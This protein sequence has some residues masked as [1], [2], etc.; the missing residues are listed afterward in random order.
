MA[1]QLVYT[2]AAKLL[3]AGRSG[4]GT[5]ARSKAISPLVVSAI[6]R[7]SQFANLRGTDRSRMIFVHRRI[8]AGN[9]RCHVLSR[10][11]DAGADYTGRTNH[12]AHHLILSPDEVSHAAAAGVTPADILRQFAWRDR[13]DE[14]ARYFS[15]DEDVPME[16]FSPLGCQSARAEWTR[17]TGQPAHARLLAW[18]GAPRSGVLLVPR[19]TEPLALLA[20]ALCE[21]GSQAWCR[22][23]TTALESTDEMSDLDWIIS[24]PETFSEIQGRCGARTI[25]DLSQPDSLPVP[26]EPA[27]LPEETQPL[28]SPPAP[29]FPAVETADPGVVQVPVVKL[30]TSPSGPTTRRPVTIPA[31]PAVKQLGAWVVA[32][33]ATVVILVILAVATWKT[34]RPKAIPLPPP[35]PVVRLTDS[36]QDAVRMLR[37]AGIPAEDAETIAKKSEG[38]ARAWASF[39][40]QFTYEINGAK[41]AFKPRQLPRPPS[42]KE[43]DGVPAWLTTLTTA[44]NEIAAFLADPAA[45]QDLTVRLDALKRIHGQ[46]RS[47]ADDLAGGG[48]TPESCDW[49]DSML[50]EAELDQLLRPAQAAKPGLDTVVAQLQQAIADGQFRQAE[51]PARHKLLSG[52]V[53]KQFGFNLKQTAAFVESGAVPKDFEKEMKRPGSGLPGTGANDSTPRP[54]AAPDLSKVKPRE[55]I[56]V[57]RGQLEQGVAVALLREVMKANLAQGTAKVKLAPL[58]IELAPRDSE[59]ERSDLLLSDDKSFYCRT[60]LT[61]DRAPRFFAD[62]RISLRNPVVKS[63]Q[64]KFGDREALVV[65]NER[66]DDWL[67]ADLGCKLTPAADTAAVSG[68]LAE[69]LQ[70]VEILDPGGGPLEVLLTPEIPGLSIAQTVAEWQVSRKSRSQPTLVFS[71]SQADDL[72]KVLGEFAA[73][74]KRAGGTSRNAKEEMKAE[75]KAA[76]GKLKQALCAALGGGLL[77]K[78]LGLPEP[79]A[80]RPQHLAQ[81]KRLMAEKYQI[82][83]AA[84]PPVG[85]SEIADLQHLEEKIGEARL[86]DELPKL[87]KKV[88]WAALAEETAAADWIEDCIQ[89]I[90]KEAKP[91]EPTI[92]MAAELKK[93][94]NISVKTR[95]GRALFKATPR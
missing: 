10:I 29:D 80:I 68:E 87:G 56:L 39:V 42:A 77:C 66:T 35:P 44:S 38:E 34:L 76:L 95:A 1:S 63:V 62:G 64:F 69:W 83:G 70:A 58:T 67:H 23:F 47:V 11:C 43:P 26:P 24:T 79:G 7:V 86:D 88:A 48:H 94:T 51:W 36:Q 5:V 16:G 33:S 82:S 25:F 22:T 81:A 61:D 45:G 91:A 15:P 84:M 73:I 89:A 59:N 49:F 14:P 90:L 20:E 28:A 93:I 71:R 54:P 2:S 50:V 78:D 60:K 32:G 75:R 6:E 31:A 41:R 21:F 37:D 46:L 27:P 8:I 9:H 53:G 74:A 92:P 13:W 72:A 4:F 3:D 52:F 19:A 30:R 18:E 40:S 17:L 55:V 65:V 57:S 85:V 12:I